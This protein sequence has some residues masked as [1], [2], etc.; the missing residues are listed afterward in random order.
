MIPRRLLNEA[1]DSEVSLVRNLFVP[2]SADLRTLAIICS[3]RKS[4][5]LQNQR[6]QTT[7]PDNTT[8]VGNLVAPIRWDLLTVHALCTR[9]SAF[10]QACLSSACQWPLRH[11]VE[12][13]SEQGV[14]ASALGPVAGWSTVGGP[15]EVRL[16]TQVQFELP[17]FAVKCSLTVVQ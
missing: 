1:Q 5:R 16:K 9:S 8:L 2:Q 14:I 4:S 15:A 12:L 13:T 3:V 17:K 11:A 6:Q 7:F 10:R